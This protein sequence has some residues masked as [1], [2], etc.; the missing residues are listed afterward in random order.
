M[1]DTLP[2]LTKLE[3]RKQDMLLTYA[4]DT[5]YTV[6]YDDL[7]HACPCAKCSPMRNEDDTSRTLRRQIEALPAEKPTVRTVGKYALAFEWQQGCSSGIYRFERVYDLANKRDPDR[8]KP[9][10]HGAW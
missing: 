8:G 2:K 3:R 5:Q 10:V 4:D 1:T 6:T 7:R 9:Y